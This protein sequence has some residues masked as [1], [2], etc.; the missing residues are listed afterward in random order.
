MIRAHIGQLFMGD[1][2]EVFIVDHRDDSRRLM[3]YTHENNALHWEEIGVEANYAADEA[4]HKPTV[5]LP[6]DSGRALLEAL[7][8][9]YQGAEDTRALRRDYDAERKRVDEQAKTLADI[10]RTLAMAQGGTRD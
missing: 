7:V 4:H 8:H 1:A 6:Y 3:H 9:H 2:I 10:A 5:V